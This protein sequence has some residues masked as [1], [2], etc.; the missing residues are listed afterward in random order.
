MLF[1]TKKAKT[2]SPIESFA[3]TVYREEI[4]VIEQA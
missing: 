1:Q 3:Y 4:Y 2:F